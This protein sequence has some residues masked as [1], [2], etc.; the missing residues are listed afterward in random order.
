MD[1]LCGTTVSGPVTHMGVVPVRLPLVAVTVVCPN[2]TPVTTPL[3]VP[4]V[5]AAGFELLHATAPGG[6]STSS[7]R[8][9]PTSTHPAA[10]R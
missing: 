10:G 7:V 4:T 6:E 5:A 8:V 3:V 2:E 1:T 9:C